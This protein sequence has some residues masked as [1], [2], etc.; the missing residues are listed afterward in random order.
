MKD[1]NGIKPVSNPAWK[2]INFLLFLHFGSN[3]CKM[4]N[5]LCNTLIINKISNKNFKKDLLK[6]IKKNKNNIIEN[7]MNYI[8]DII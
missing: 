8:Y 3:M 6:L 7:K 4:I 5:Q 1:A 2:S